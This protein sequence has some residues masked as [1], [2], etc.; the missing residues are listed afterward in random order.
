MVNSA[1]ARV[2]SVNVGRPAS[3]ETP[4]GPVQSAIVKRPVR[5]R[6]IQEQLTASR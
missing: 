2:V 3:L 1:S 6:V 4:R 5:G